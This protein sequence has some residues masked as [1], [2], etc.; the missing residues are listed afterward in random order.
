MTYTFP[1]LQ[2]DVFTQRAGYGNPVAVVLDKDRV[3]D[4]D[5]MQRFAH[6]TNLSETVFMLPLDASAAARGYELRIFTPSEELPFAGHPT[7]GSAHA[8]LHWGVVS[9]GDFVQRCGLGDVPIAGSLQDGVSVRVSRPQLLDVKISGEELDRVL[10]LAAENPM[11]LDVGPRWIVARVESVE[12]LY[13]VDPDPMELAAFERAHEPASGTT[14]YAL[15]EQGVPHVRSFAPMHGIL[16]DPVCGSGNLC[17]GEHLRL[18]GS[19]VAGDTWTARQGRA[20]GRDGH[21]QITLLEDGALLGERATIMV[22]GTLRY[23]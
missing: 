2:I 3:L 1:F 18:G 13:A 22:E 7:V 8:A 10:G 14:L 12:A 20:L 21:V 15:D 16:E 11:L 9:P 23:P 6:W 17:V 19:R 5:A 4:G